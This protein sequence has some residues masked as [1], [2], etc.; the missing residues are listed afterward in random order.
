MVIG[1]SQFRT[2][3]DLIGEPGL[4]DDARF[5]S[6]ELRGRNGA[7]LSARMAEW[8]AKRTSREALDELERARLPAG[9]VYSPREALDDAHVRALGF[10]R[11]VEVPGAARPVG[12]PGFPI[13]MSRTPGEIRTRAPAIGEHTDSI[14]AELGYD[15]D[16]IRSLREAGAV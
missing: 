2:W 10:L 9:P 14:L 11:P 8:C 3:C 13:D 6:D 15:A 5:A 7:E 4:V 12:T 16:A 1:P